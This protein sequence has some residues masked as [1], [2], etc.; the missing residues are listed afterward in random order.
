MMPKLQPLLER[1]ALLY[2]IE[3]NVSDRLRL[4]WKWW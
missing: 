4:H 2:E 1:L 3:L